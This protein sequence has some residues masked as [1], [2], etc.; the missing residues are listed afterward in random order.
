MYYEHSHKAGDVVYIFYRNPHTQDVANIQAAAVVNHPEN[1]N[2]LAIF[3]Y[4]NYYP[5]TND[6]AIYSSKE[7]A[8]EAYDYYYGS[9]SDGVL[10]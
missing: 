8:D 9:F 4:E 7:E 5:L 10:E 2:E 3:V 6:M 1:S